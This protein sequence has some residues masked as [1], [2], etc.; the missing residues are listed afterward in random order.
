M[1]PFWLEN[2]LDVVLALLLRVVA[3]G[4]CLL[5]VL[6]CREEFLGWRQIFTFQ[7]MSCGF[8]ADIAWPIPLEDF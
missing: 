7:E 2:L 6:V 8:E 3:A 5:T 1:R 4:E